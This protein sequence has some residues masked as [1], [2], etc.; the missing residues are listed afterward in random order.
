MLVSLYVKKRMI[1]I[2]LLYGSGPLR[3]YVY[4]NAVCIRVR[5][6]RYAYHMMHHT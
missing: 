2:A 4:N 5:E 1:F 6:V 3:T